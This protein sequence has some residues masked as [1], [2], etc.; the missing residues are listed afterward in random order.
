MRDAAKT[1]TEGRRIVA[2]VVV[3]TVVVAFGVI[4][5]FGI[6]VA[7]GVVVA[8]GLGAMNTIE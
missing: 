4:V 7:F 2:A 1:L 5:A 6:V 8:I 3:G